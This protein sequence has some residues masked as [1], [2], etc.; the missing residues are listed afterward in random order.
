MKIVETSIALA[1]VAALSLTTGAAAVTTES[2]DGGSSEI[3]IADLDAN[4]MAFST[5]APGLATPNR[6]DDSRR[7]V[8]CKARTCTGRDP[9]RTRCDRHARTIRTKAPWYVKPRSRKYVLELRYSKK[10]RAIWSRIS[11][12]NY[13]KAAYT[14]KWHVRVV[15]GKKKRRKQGSN[16]SFPRDW[17][18]MQSAKGFRTG[19]ACWAAYTSPNWYRY[20]TKWTKL[21]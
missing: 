7:R 1:V 8:A 21:P 9:H 11:I 4:G 12:R 17:S 3:T 10:C 15:G 20:C 19:R 6:L 13:D 16:L 14:T 5:G 18:P 2:S